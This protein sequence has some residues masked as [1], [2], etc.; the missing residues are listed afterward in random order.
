[1]DQL[2]PDDADAKACA[3]RQAIVY[4]EPGLLEPGAFDAV[5]GEGVRVGLVT[6]VALIDARSSVGPQETLEQTRLM[7]SDAPLAGERA[8]AFC[9][10]VRIAPALVLT[11]NHC[12]E[13]VPCDGLEVSTTY[14]ARDARVDTV[15]CARVVF[16]DPEADFALL[17]TDS[18]PVPDAPG[19]EPVSI[20]S[21]TPAVLVSHPLGASTRVDP[22]AEV[23]PS[24]TPG[25]LWARADAFTG[26]SGGGLFTLEGEFV[27]IVTAGLADFEWDEETMCMGLAVSSSRG[28]ER[29]V[30]A[31]IVFER[32]C[33]QVGVACDVPTG[34][35]DR[36]DDPIEPVGCE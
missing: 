32:S 33:E 36:S 30:P 22:D 6:E 34:T 16:A 23:R 26:S 8:L 20:A 35:R 13:Q 9:S 14:D 15:G 7:C 12:L 29:V 28:F 2:D 27:G 1:V 5:V 3:R 18:D 21:S 24:A 25:R 10:G 11:A 19:V 17:L 31:E 4:G